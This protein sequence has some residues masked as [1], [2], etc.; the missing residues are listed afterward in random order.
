LKFKMALLV[1][2][3]LEKGQ[4]RDQDDC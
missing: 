3:P 1:S 2:I 4:Q